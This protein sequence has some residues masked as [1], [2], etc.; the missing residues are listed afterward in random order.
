[1]KSFQYIII[2]LIFCPIFLMGQ[3]LLPNPS[4]EDTVD[5]KITPL[6]LPANWKA[7]NREGFNY[8]TPYNYHT[9]DPRDSIYA[10]PYNHWGYQKARSGKAYIGTVLL[11]LFSFSPGKR[12]PRRE[13]MQAKLKRTL[14]ADSTYCFQ[15]YV[16]LA[17]SMRYASRGQLGVYFSTTAVYG[18]NWERL[19]YTPQILVSPNQYVTDK[20]NWVKYSATYKAL[21]GEKYITLGN[22]NDTTIID[23]LF[24]GGGVESNIDNLDIYYYL[25]DIFLGS[26]DSLPDSTTTGIWENKIKQKLRVYPNPFKNTFVV[27]SQTLEKLHFVL[28]NSIGQKLPFKVQQIGKRYSIS[29]QNLPKGLYWLK[30]NDGNKAEA[31]KLVKE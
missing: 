17:D 30:I 31:L 13:Y 2:T 26:C 3:N 16:S 23:T 22:F 1:M 5:V 28:Y 12:N 10:V 19:P 4:F 25:D 27:E 14:K 6:Y 21:G 29:T 9:K 7:A 11:H 24:V 8:Y 15:L 18:N 20:T